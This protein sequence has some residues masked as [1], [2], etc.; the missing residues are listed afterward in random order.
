[1][2]RVVTQAIAFS[3]LSGKVRFQSLSKATEERFVEMQANPE[4]ALGQA[5]YKHLQAKLA[6]YAELQGQYAVKQSEMERTKRAANVCG[7]DMPEPKRRE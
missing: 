1:M 5:E 2:R 6:K 3:A 4:S 7:L